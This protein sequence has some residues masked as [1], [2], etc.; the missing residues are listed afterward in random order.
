MNEVEG[1]ISVLFLGEIEHFYLVVSGFQ[2][3]YLLATYHS[4]MVYGDCEVMLVKYFAMQV[5]VN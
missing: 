4:D 1:Q 5:H 3:D 2:S